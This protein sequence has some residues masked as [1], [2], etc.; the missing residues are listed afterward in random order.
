[1]MID[2]DRPTDWRD[3]QNKVAQILNEAGLEAA[4]DREIVLARGKVRVDVFARDPKQTP[5]GTYLCEC[6]HWQVP[7]SKDVVHGFRTVVTDSGANRGFLISS[8]GFQ[9]GARDAV[10][11]SNVDLLTWEQFQTLFAVRWFQSFMASALVREGDALHEYTEPIN[12]RIARKAAELPQDRRKRFAQLRNQYAI[13][14]LGLLMLWL[15]PFGEPT[16]PSLPLRASL[17]DRSDELRIPANILDA[18]ALRPLMVAVVEFYREA[19]AQFD[20]VFGGRA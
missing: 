14:S 9:S 2:A 10:Q 4:V 15:Q 17:G 16:P 18:T 7:A 11:Y 3:L 13:A 20:E 1:M 5:P 19:T 12:S 8:A 6:K